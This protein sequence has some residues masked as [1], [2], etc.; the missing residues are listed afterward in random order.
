MIKSFAFGDLTQ[1]PAPL[2]SP[3]VRGGTESSSPKRRILTGM[4][5]RLPGETARGFLG[6]ENSPWEDPE[7]KRWAEVEAEAEELYGE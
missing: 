7:V 1:S 2:P 5:R 3:E 4:E 6:R